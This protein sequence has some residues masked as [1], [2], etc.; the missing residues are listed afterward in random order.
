M[1]DVITV[2]SATVDVFARTEFCEMIRDKKKEECI[3]YPVGSKILI[4]EL[5]LSSGGGGTNAAVAL[6]RL[7]HKVAF[8]GK[9]G[10]FENSH[11]VIL[12]LQKEHVNTSL[13]I[14]KPNSRTGYS[15]ILDSIKHDRTILVFRGSNNDLRYNEVKASK[16]KA[17][18]FYFSTMMGQSYK[19]LEKLAL[20][21]EKNKIKIMFNTSSYL[22]KKGIPY[23]RPIL[24]RTDILVLNKEEAM[25]LAGKNKIKPLLRKLHKA[26]PKIVAIT[27]GKNGVYV[28]D[29][30]H[31]YFA[32]PH[33]VKV[34]ETTGAGDAFASSFLSGIIRKNDIEFAI[35]LGMTNAESVI[36][37]H[38]AKNKLLTYKEA[39]KEMKKRPI[40]VIK[41]II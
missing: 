34:V 35:K 40:K 3:A 13:I 39:L 27:D 17:K 5:I 20:Y 8:L 26:G 7:G 4:K 36:Q 18:W 1:F 28:F 2:G 33:K 10:T 12:D 6:S 25:L 16:L 21:A 30:N 15:I 14:R 11:R 37:Y 9:M 38:G 41:R 23:L 32:K 22:A 31:F 19:T 29:G 24:K